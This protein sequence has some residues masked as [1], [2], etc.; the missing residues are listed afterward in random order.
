MKFRQTKFWQ[1][2]EK[3]DKIVGNSSMRCT[4]DAVIYWKL[5][6]HFTFNKILEIGVY[7]GLTS[8]LMLENSNA[9]L[10]GVDH[11]LKLDVF[12]SVYE[13]FADRATF[14]SSK[15]Q[16]FS[17]TETFD[18][19]LIDG[20]HAVDAAY[21]DL[22]KFTPLLSQTGILAIDDYNEVLV[23][24]T[25][26]KLRS[27]GLVPLIQAEQTEFW[28][29]PDQDRSEFLDNLLIDKISQFILLH[30]INLH[31]CTVLKAKTV[32][33]FTDNIQ[34]FDKVLELYDV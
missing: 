9:T 20:D 17:T 19:I 18:F 28:H 27:L 32:K 3:F 14:I 23:P 22:L 33:A 15:S 24:K 5:F 10:I 26:H 8:G 1:N 13:D 21:Q 6:Q 31:N 11:Y 34:L 16:N 25:V 4:I 29:Y 2:Y 7:Q 12:N 30:N